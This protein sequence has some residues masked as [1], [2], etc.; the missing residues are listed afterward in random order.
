MSAQNPYSCGANICPLK[1]PGTRG[2]GT[3]GPC[4][5]LPLRMTPADRENL[6]RGIRWLAERAAQVDR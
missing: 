5:C 4:H 2:I 6:R 3:N 1:V